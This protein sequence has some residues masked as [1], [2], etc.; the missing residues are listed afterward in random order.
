MIILG[1]IF[2]I[3]W[4]HSLASSGD[5]LSSS[6]MSAPDFAAASASFGRHYFIFIFL[7]NDTDLDLFIASSIEP[8][9]AI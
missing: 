7:V 5:M 4:L 2:L 9:T 1:S 3:R 6:T 8:T